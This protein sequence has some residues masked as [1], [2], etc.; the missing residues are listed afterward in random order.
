ML[1]FKEYLFVHAANNTINSLEKDSCI[2]MSVNRKLN[3]EL[4]KKSSQ[5]VLFLTYGIFIA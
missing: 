1:S 4:I 3:P 5:A 2:V